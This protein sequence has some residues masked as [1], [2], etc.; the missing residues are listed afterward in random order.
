MIPLSERTA[1]EKVN[2]PFSSPTDQSQ[3]HRE[4]IHNQIAQ[5]AFPIY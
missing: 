2:E 1:N 5:N 4:I 3:S